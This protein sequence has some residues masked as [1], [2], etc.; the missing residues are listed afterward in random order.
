MF[1]FY[2]HNPKW[3]V[4]VLGRVFRY[5][6]SFVL[7]RIWH[8][9][10]LLREV[11]SAILSWR[12]CEGLEP[13]IITSY[14]FVLLPKYR[15]IWSGF[16]GDPNEVPSKFSSLHIVLPTSKLTPPGFFTRLAT[17]ITSHPSRELF[18]DDASLEIV[19]P[20]YIVVTNWLCYTHWSTQCYASECITICSWQ[21]FSSFNISW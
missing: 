20:F 5:R 2:P 11:S 12:G 19:S 15:G 10:K 16:D 14:W 6:G 21:P 18:F 3:F 13:I 9:R 8:W 4:D 1:L 17:A 7:N